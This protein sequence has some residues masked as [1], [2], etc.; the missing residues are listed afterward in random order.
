MTARVLFTF[1]FEFRDLCSQQNF[2]TTLILCQVSLLLG[3][4]RDTGPPCAQHVQYDDSASPHDGNAFRGKLSREQFALLC[5]KSVHNCACL[6]HYKRSTLF[7]RTLHGEG[8]HD[9]SKEAC[10]L[11]RCSLHNSR[12]G[13]TVSERTL[14]IFEN[15]CR[16][17]FFRIAIW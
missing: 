12:R 11:K 8:N 15:L 3:T 7:R 14:C 5:V 10:R 6:S 4:Q 1:Y 9:Q 13:W 17:I 16:A 2:G